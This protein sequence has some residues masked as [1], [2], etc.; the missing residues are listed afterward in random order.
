MPW[1]NDG[2]PLLRR[3]GFVVRCEW[4]VDPGAHVCF[5]IRLGGGQGTV[6]GKGRVVWWGKGSRGRASL[7]A[8]IFLDLDGVSRATVDSA[9][10]PPGP[11]SAIEIDVESASFQPTDATPFVLGPSGSLLT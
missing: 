10:G 4:R 11:R 2:V 8:V 6:S 5:S 1:W 7:V 9:V 3:D